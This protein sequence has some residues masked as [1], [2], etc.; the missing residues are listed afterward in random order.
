MDDW[1][2]VVDA[3][4]EL[5]AGAV[6]ELRDVGFVVIPGPVAPD[7]M[8]QFA[9]AYDAAVACATPEDV[10]IG[11]TTTRVND[12]VN[13][14]PEFDG[15]YVYEPVLEACCR[16]IGQ[17]FKLSTMHART[18]RPYSR[19]QN[20]H[21]D[22]KREGDGWP[23]VG[24][25]LMVDEF[26]TDN[27]ATRFVPGSHKWPTIPADFPQDPSADYE[28]QV[29][30][31]GPAGSVIVYNGSA[32]HGHTTNRVGE[33][34]RSIQGAYIRR[35][36]EPAVNQAARIRPETLGRIGHLAKYVLAI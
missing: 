30:A 24:F 1:F 16:I 36:A 17:P 35:D 4:C 9:E 34:R 7:R 8:A 33:P 32:W 11:S 18:V 31:C 5:S 15:L 29:L 21:V 20:L 22:F 12:F 6:Q 14:G 19:A 23:M 27:G 13:R 25:I 28:G 3:R 2:S 10:A 26:R